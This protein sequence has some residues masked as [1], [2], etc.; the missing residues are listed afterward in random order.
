MN[1]EIIASILSCVL[2]VKNSFY[3]CFSKEVKDDD[4]RKWSLIMQEKITQLDT[5]KLNVRLLLICISNIMIKVSF[6]L[7]DKYILR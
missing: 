2:K 1:E 4:V 6:S 7:H 3:M 5:T